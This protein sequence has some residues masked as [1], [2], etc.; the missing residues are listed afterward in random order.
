LELS[1]LSA[2]SRYDRWPEND[3]QQNGREIDRR[4]GRGQPL[5][6]L[7]RLL[8]LSDRFLNEQ[9]SRVLEIRLECVIRREKEM[10]VQQEKEMA[11][12]MSWRTRE[13]LGRL[14]QALELQEEIP[15]T[16]TLRSRLLKCFCDVARRRP[17]LWIKI[18]DDFT[19]EI[20]TAVS[21][22]LARDLCRRREAQRIRERLDRQSSRVHSTTRV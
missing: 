17:Q 16:E 5:I 9:M 12:D 18:A 11:P 14:A 10:I 19:G 15:R 4:F 7:L 21:K 2:I 20:G 22:A 1:Y 6:S 3:L 8:K 13:V